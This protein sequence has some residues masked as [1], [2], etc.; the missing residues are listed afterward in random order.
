MNAS[1]NTES[2][3]WEKN[4]AVQRTARP[5]GALVSTSGARKGPALVASG[6]LG[7]GGLDVRF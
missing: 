4:C 2:P 3:N 6:P 5:A 7:F 1:W